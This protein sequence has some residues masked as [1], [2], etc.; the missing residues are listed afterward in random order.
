MV[1]SWKEEFNRKYNEITSTGDNSVIDE[2]NKILCDA[3]DNMSSLYNRLK[4]EGIL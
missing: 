3:L 4:K 1:E 2:A